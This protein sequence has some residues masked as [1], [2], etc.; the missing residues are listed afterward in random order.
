MKYGIN[1]S[2][3]KTNN[4]TVGLMMSTRILPTI[5]GNPKKRT[6]GEYATT[7]AVVSDLPE[8]TAAFW[9]TLQKLRKMNANN[10]ARTITG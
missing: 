2:T 8:R 9:S 7:F 6:I 10:K 3:D 1:T 4:N 5:I